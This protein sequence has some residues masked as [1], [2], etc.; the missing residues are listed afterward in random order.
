MRTV[1]L[2]SRPTTPK[3]MVPTTEAWDAIGT[4]EVRSHVARGAMV[5]PSLGRRF[6]TDIFSRRV[7]ELLSS[8]LGFDFLGA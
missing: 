8:T 5:G 2:A 1:G 4:K 6:R 3:R 7:T